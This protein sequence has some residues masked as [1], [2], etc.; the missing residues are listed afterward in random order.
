MIAALGPA[1]S[2]NEVWLLAFG[3]SLFLVFPTVYAVAVSGF[4]FGVMMLLWSLV[5][6]ALG[7]ELRHLI[8]D[9]MWHLVCDALFRLGSVLV[10]VL[11]GVATGNLI[12]GLPLQ[13]DGWFS[14]PLF[15]TFCVQGPVGLVDWYTASTGALFLAIAFR[16]HE[17]AGYLVLRTQGPSPPRSRPGIGVP[18]PGWAR[19]PC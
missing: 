1:W 2:W 6:R 16:A 13:A 12:R 8:D 10:A 3:G 19:S 14:L 18:G 15:T 4:Y 5:L 9:P 7:I 11:L 17:S